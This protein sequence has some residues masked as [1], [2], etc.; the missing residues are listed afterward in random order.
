MP[1][2][3][4]DSRA[5]GRAGEAAGQ[6][7]VARAVALEEQPR[8]LQVVRRGGEYRESAVGQ[9]HRAG[10]AGFCDRYVPLAAEEIGLV[11]G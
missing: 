4:L 10:R 1:A 7:A 5:F 6:L 3:V 11:P 8:A 9:R 2:L